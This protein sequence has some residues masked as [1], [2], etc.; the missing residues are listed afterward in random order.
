[1]SEIHWNSFGSH[2]RVRLRNSRP[3]TETLKRHGVFRFCLSA[4]AALVLLLPVRAWSQGWG[5]WENLG[6]ILLEEPD[7]VSWGSN[8]IDCFA[9]GTD[10][11]MWHRWWDG[12]QW[13]GWES[14]GGILLEQ[15]DCVSW[16]SNRLDCFARG[17]DKAMWH[18]WWG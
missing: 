16:G 4:L 11:A 7:C 9:R 14:L 17:T 8:R 5:G 15:P 6:G 1:M 10:Q 18:R 3:G 13:G 2:C 12:W